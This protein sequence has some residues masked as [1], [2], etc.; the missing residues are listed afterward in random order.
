MNEYSV[1]SGT[2]IVAILKGPV[3]KGKINYEL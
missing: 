2:S 1:L 3:Y